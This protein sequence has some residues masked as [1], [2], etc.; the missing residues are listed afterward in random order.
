MAEKLYL[1]GEGVMMTKISGGGML[2]FGTIQNLNLATAATFKELF[3]GSGLFPVASRAFEKSIECSC[4]MAS[5]EK[6]FIEL[7]QG[8]ASGSPTTIERPVFAEKQT[9]D[10]GTV[11]VDKSSY[12]AGYTHV[13][14]ADGTKLTLVAGAPDS[15][16]YQESTPASGELTFNA[17][18][19]T[20]DVYIDY[21]YNYDYAA[22]ADSVEAL[23]VAADVLPATFELF[24]E[25]KITEGGITRGVEIVFFKCKPTVDMKLVFQ[26]DFNVPNFTFRV[27][28][29]M[30]PDGKI[31]H[32][33]IV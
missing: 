2:K 25:C 18:M 28:N 32:Y 19:N 33:T 9:V 17:D 14:D 20:N 12:K 26:R 4:D 30:R 11:T 7:S 15:G 16:E 27:V 24:Y 31:G 21:V 22:N 3:A 13:T 29:P 1:S 5:F 6:D 10:T 8:L 23:V